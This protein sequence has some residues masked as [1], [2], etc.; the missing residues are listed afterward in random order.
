MIDTSDEW[1][2]TRTG[3]I[4][5]RIVEDD[6]PTSEI[7]TQA[8]IRALEDAGIEPKEVELII[9]ATITPDMLTPS[10]AC[11]VQEKLGA[12]K[13]CAFDLSAACSGFIY[14]LEIA[15]QFIQ[16]NSYETVLVIAADT[17][18]K[19]T[20]WKD[21]NTCVLLG[22]GAGAAVL[23]PTDE[24]K[25]LQSSFLA[26]DGALA[27]ILEVPAG[28]SRAP[29]THQTVD[30]RLHYLKME[31]KEVFRSAVKVMSEAV[32]KILSI[33]K[34]KIE[35]VDLLIPHQANIRIIDAMIAELKIPKERVF[36]NLH[37]YGNTSAASNAICLDE[38]IREGRVKE[39]DIIV[40]TSVGAGLTWASNLIRW[41]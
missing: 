37:K 36:V 39:D 1:I 16:T 40:M 25:G 6:T 10:T 41:G 4:E 38:A 35:D 24:G 18:S 3:I 20:D 21:R 32:R 31:G 28:G 27:R 11:L 8:S 5:R 9:L 17:L 34:L 33:N 30:D 14:G 26:A 2:R 7:A 15:R 19:I 23:R 13:A 12:K 22:D 29:A